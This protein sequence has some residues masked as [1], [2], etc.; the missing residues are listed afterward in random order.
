MRIAISDSEKRARLYGAAVALIIF[1]IV[2]NLAEGLVS[3]YLGLED[4]SFALFGFGVDSFIE[5]IS[6]IGVAHMIYRVRTRPES[7]RDE[8][9]RTA[10]RVT[11][12]AFYILVAGLLITGIHNIVIGHQP[13]TTFWGIVV[14]L[15]S[16]L[17]MWALIA[18]KTK[19][20]RALD[21]PAILA[22]AQCTRVCIYMSV[23]LLFSSALYEYASIPYVDSAGALG[24]AWFSYREGRECFEK[25]KN[26]SICSCDHC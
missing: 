15:I 18:G 10:L 17:I 25:A 23:I 12:T 16:I 6:A 5:V 8:F 21:S 22:D 3:V 1:T 9:E 19:V 11:G 24:L 13:E 7:S 14:S 26:D 4:E 2:Y 20:G